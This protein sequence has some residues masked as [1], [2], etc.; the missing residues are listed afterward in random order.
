MLTRLI[1]TVLPLTDAARVFVAG[2][3]VSFPVAAQTP[4][5]NCNNQSRT[6]QQAAGY[7]GVSSTT[8]S[9]FIFTVGGQTFQTPS[10]CQQGYAFYHGTVYSCGP[11]S[12]GTHCKATGFDVDID[13]ATGGSCPDITGLNPGSWTA[14]ADVP[15]AIT[16]A[17]RCKAPTVTHTF[18]WSAVVSSCTIQVPIDGEPGVV[19]VL[20]ASGEVY[21]RA[22]GSPEFALSGQ[23]WNPLVGAYELAQDGTLEQLPIDLRTACSTYAPVH[24]VDVAAQ[25]VIENWSSPDAVQIK[26]YEIVGRVLR[27]GQFDVTC[28]F[29]VEHEGELVPV[30]RRLRHDGRALYVLPAS[31]EEFSAYDAEY[32]RRDETFWLV[33]SMVAP[34]HEWVSNPIQVPL[35]SSSTFDPVADGPDGVKRVARRVASPGG[36]SV[37]EEY[38][39]DGSSIERH[40][41]SRSTFDS[42]ERVRQFSAFANPIMIGEGVRRSGSFTE[43][44]QLD[45]VAGG[46]RT[47]VKTTIRR[48]DVLSVG[49]GLSP[50]VTESDQIW[51][52]WR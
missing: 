13:L 2:F 48:A 12:T 16:A 23:L 32:P 35:F 50:L 24:G 42:M 10:S 37:S 43:T 25:V 5:A 52:V 47:V 46:R 18:D 31:A 11:A 49:T 15:A 21:L 36:G 4:A 44:D 22:I 20:G 29:A 33:C 19:E 6:L 40:P 39:L 8:C 28:T 30:S 45:G 38:A 1:V 26:T 51:N 17:M 14:W 3:C 9:Q 7:T 27:S 41:L 34:L